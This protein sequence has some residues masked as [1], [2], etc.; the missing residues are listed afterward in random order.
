MW[1]SL[2][3]GSVVCVSCFVSGVG[4]LVAWVAL[5]GFCL[6]MIVHSVLLCFVLR[7]DCWLWGCL[8]L[9]LFVLC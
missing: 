3:V 9:G 4:F 6:G 7:S 8:T 5:R 2:W 1:L